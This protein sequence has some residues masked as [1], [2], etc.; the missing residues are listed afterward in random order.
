MTP[1]T[2]QMYWQ[3]R[4]TSAGSLSGAQYRLI[5]NLN[6]LRLLCEKLMLPSSGI[7]K[8]TL[9]YPPET[10]YPTISL[11]SVAI[12]N[13][14]ISFQA[15][16]NFGDC[17]NSKRQGP[18]GHE[19]RAYRPLKQLLRRLFVGHWM[20]CLISTRVPAYSNCRLPWPSTLSNASEMRD[21]SPSNRKL[22]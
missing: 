18:Q 1:K 19:P 2:R 9:V 6:V 13:V 22:S 14:F 3:L 12:R 4:K 20:K 21:P 17:F 10:E 15:S 5:A 8:R 16:N 11:C 7:S